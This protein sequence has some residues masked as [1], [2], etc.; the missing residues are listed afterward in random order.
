MSGS[1]ADR[2]TTSNGH[3]HAGGRPRLPDTDRAIVKAVADLMAE[4][5]VRG[6]TINAVADRAGVARGTVYRRWPNRSAMIADAIRA[7]RSWEPLEL[8]DDLEHNI[9]QQA[10][11]A[12]TVLAEPSFQAMIPALA[13]MQ[14]NGESD[15]VVRSTVFPRRRQMAEMFQRLA[16]SAGYRTDIPPELPNDLLVGAMLYRLLYDGR[17][18]TS[19]EVAGMVD[20]IL[21]GI[22]R[23][24]ARP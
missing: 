16:G 17:P 14:L 12:R 9:R 20:V 3:R 19:D 13:E 23:P 10:E 1:S 22:R 24:D 2:Q 6:T 8:G 5:G 11:E 4:Q 7:S 21:A 18:P 15:E